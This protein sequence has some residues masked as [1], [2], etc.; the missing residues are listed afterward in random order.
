MIF[1]K[2][3]RNGNMV[4]MYYFEKCPLGH[5]NGR[6]GPRRP[7]GSNSE[8]RSDTVNA[9]KKRFVRLCWRSFDTHRDAPALLTF[10]FAEH[11]TDVKM[12][13]IRFK[14][15]IRRLRYEYPELEYIAVPEFTKK[16]RV[17]F[18]LLVW[19]IP[20]Q[21]VLLERQYRRI[22][23]I[24]GNGFID[25]VQTNGHRK[26]ITYLSKYFVKS[27]YDVRLV[28]EKAYVR[29]RGVSTIQEV[30]TWS[31]NVDFINP[32]DNFDTIKFTCEYD[33]KYLGRGLY[34]LFEINEN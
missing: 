9:M 20:P 8:R 2:T 17:H 32:V 15:G 4:E 14:E 26:L 6:Q 19:G 21:H 34:Y 10:T 30:L 18:H 31:Y 25:A 1:T 5:V 12:A 27:A 29:S 22:A 13:Y 28:N 23:E 7:W 16:G 3:V 11:I 24:W 33:T